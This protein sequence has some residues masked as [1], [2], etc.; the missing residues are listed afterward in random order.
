MTGR[1]RAAGR[2]RTVAVA[3]PA[4]RKAPAKAKAKAKAAAAPYLFNPGPEFSDRTRRDGAGIVNAGRFAVVAGSGG[5]AVL[6]R[7]Q[8]PASDAGGHYRA[9]AR[10]AACQCQEF[11]ER[12]ACPHVLAA[13]IVRAGYEGGSIV[14]SGGGKA[15]RRRARSAQP[16]RQRQRQRRTWCGI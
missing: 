10:P 12:A 13:M 9:T 7:P 8:L 3:A 11:Q 1:G 14:G 15:E 16:A 4:A 5:N 2:Q 6:V